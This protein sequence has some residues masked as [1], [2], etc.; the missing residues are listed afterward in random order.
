MKFSLRFSLFLIK[1]IDL[2]VG[3]KPYTL[4]LNLAIN[5]SSK[6]ISSPIPTE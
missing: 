6:E 2:G 4:Q 5:S 1:L 3:L